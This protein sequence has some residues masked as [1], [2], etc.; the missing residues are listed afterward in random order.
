MHKVI[1]HLADEAVLSTK[2]IHD[3]QE[4]MVHGRVQEPVV[5]GR[6]K[7]GAQKDKLG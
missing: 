5:W 2:E 6:G 7:V 4:E 1:S 3:E